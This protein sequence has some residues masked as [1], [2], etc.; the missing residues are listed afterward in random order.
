MD[1]VVAG[2][3]NTDLV[4]PV[5]RLARASETISGGDLALFPGGKGANQ[6]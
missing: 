6:A 2:S 4:L 5:E 1:I 3:A